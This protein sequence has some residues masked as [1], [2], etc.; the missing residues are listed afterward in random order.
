MLTHHSRLTQCDEAKPIC[1]NCSRISIPCD[2]TPPGVHSETAEPVVRKRGRPRKNWTVVSIAPG[3]TSQSEPAAG[4]TPSSTTLSPDSSWHVEKPL[5]LPWGVE[6][7]ELFFHYTNEVCADLGIGD[8][9][10]WKDRIPRLGFRKHGVLYLLLA[11]SA[12]HLARQEPSR[13]GQLEERAETHL[14]IGLRRATEILP[15]LSAENCAEL[16]V[17]TIL[18]WVYSFAKR[19]TPMNLLLVADGAE[20]PW[21]ELFKGV[22]IVVETIGISTVFAGELGPW[23]AEVNGDRQVEATHP[24][25]DNLSAVGWEST[26][27]RLSGLAASAPDERVRDTCQ[28]ALSMM[29]WCFQETYGTTA[30]PKPAVDVKFNVIM[31]WLYCLSDEYVDYLK[32][33]EPISLIILTHFAVLLQA[34]EAAW[35][36]K[37]WAAHILRGVCDILGPAWEEWLQWPSLHIS[38]R[39]NQQGQTRLLRD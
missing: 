4:S 17:A 10:L 6:D 36:M 16:Y 1:G 15:K 7:L 11:V 27:G 19:P 29:M 30:N 39:E 2:Y 3:T 22:R 5:H 32:E 23:P 13:R 18:V 26:L 8:A 31:V 28:N 35:F 38:A 37:G 9:Q 24:P 33:K 14:A 20:V 34:L 25:Q 21:W 12:L